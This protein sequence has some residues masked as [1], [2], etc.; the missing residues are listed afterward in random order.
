M[1]KIGLLGGTFNPIHLGH[2]RAAE[3]ICFRFELH[4]VF[5]IPSAYPP[6]KKKEG[7]LDAPLRAEMVR[8]AIADNPRFAYSGVELERPGKSYSIETIEHFCRQFGSGTQVYFIV[9]LDA[10]L[11][12][13]TW[14][15]Y[16]ALFRLCHFVVM[17]RP[18]FEKIF[19]RE[20]LPVELKDEFCYDTQ[21][22]G[23][24]HPSGF[25]IYP[26]EVTAMDI[27]S[28]RI[29]QWVREGRSIKYLVPPVVEAFIHSQ[30]LYLK[31]DIEAAG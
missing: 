24:A 4:R 9:G 23:Y 14:K 22:G 21:K 11:E 13:H 29:R 1:K 25:C 26:A 28:T 17:T 6:H 3:E 5:F 30:K 27:S 15:D 12:I 16:A 20:H 18:G 10:F 2:L 7:I 19:S 31:K 8:R